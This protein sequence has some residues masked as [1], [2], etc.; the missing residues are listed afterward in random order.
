MN[1]NY[2]IDISRGITTVRFLKPPKLVHLLSAST[3]V[4]ESHASKYRVYDVSCGVDIPTVEIE[5]LSQFILSK[6][7][8]PGKAAI[9]ARQDLSFGLSRMLNA[10]L[11][12]GNVGVEVNVF[13]TTVE[14][15]AWLNGKRTVRKSAPTTAAIAN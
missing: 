1:G 8:P 10:L 13:R 6:D 12:S 15:Q 9:V 14:A 3:D 7:L 5:K 11:E 2:R 4:L